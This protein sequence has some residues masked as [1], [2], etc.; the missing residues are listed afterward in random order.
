MAKSMGWVIFYSFLL[1][2]GLG[3]SYMAYT[4]FMHTKKLLATGI[5]TKA[6]IIGYKTSRGESNTLYSPVFEYT[7]HQNQKQTYT[8]T[9]DSYPPPYQINDVVSIIYDK[10]NTS[11]MK[12]LSFWDLYRGSVITFMIAS[13]LLVI[14]FSYLAYRLG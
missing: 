14:G 1:L 3:L 4:Q 7:D 8:S 11:K 2:L 10:K 13:P 9:I 6:T 12:V 5:K